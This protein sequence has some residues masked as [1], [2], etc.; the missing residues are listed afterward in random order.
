ME[1]NNKNR[2]FSDTRSTADENRATGMSNTRRATPFENDINIINNIN[3][4]IDYLKIRIIGK[5]TENDV[6]FRS[7][8][9]ILL[10]NPINF[11]SKLTN[12]YGFFR[13]YD[14]DTFVFGNSIENR[15]KTNEFC[16]YL[17]LKG[18]GCRMFELRCRNEGLD[19][20]S[21]WIDLFNTILKFR[22]QNYDIN[23]YRIDIA[24]DDF[25][26][27]IKVSDLKE[28]IDSGCFISKLRKTKEE[29]TLEFGKRVNSKGFSFT[30]GG[31]SSR[32]LCIY[33]KVAERKARGVDVD[34]EN[35]IRYESRYFHE[36]ADWAAIQILT[37]LENNSFGKV[38]SSLIGGMIEFKESIRR[39]RDK[40]FREKTWDKW[41]KL[42]NTSEKIEFKSQEKLEL[43]IT[44]NKKKLW[45]VNVPYKILTMIYLVDPSNFIYFINLCLL[46][47]IG[48]LGKNDLQRVNYDLVACNK[49]PLYYDEA[50]DLVIN[51][52]NNKI[53]FGD[54]PEY[55]QQLFNLTSSDIKEIENNPDIACDIL[56]EREELIKR[57]NQELK[58]KRGDDY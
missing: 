47:G 51:Y 52:V 14:E 38:S 43:D 31:K 57:T 54:V 55:I 10:I 13:T 44:M 33:D 26:G 16:W 7:L 32:Q 46:K 42:L 6:F 58:K 30:I 37:G 8:L 4:C 50:K 5:W 25:S 20:R 24:M 49:K 36:N 40:L 1:N 3:H 18:H 45:M 48:K 17:E 39:T 21:C 22:K 15:T 9:S 12:E 11:D 2:S 23:F 29:E 35:W 34:K 28:K 27:L 53:H 56:L 41:A 19:V